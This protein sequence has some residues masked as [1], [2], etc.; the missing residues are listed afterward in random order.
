MRVVAMGREGHTSLLVTFI[1]LKCIT[2]VLANDTCRI[3]CHMG[4]RDRGT[5]T[6]EVCAEKRCPDETVVC[7]K[8]DRRSAYC[9][10]SWPRR[11]QPIALVHVHESRRVKWG[12]LVRVQLSTVLTVT[13]VRQG[14]GGVVSDLQWRDHATG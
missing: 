7:A 9:I 6:G 12:A 4:G 11:K 14:P 3:G 5:L 10:L 13:R 8:T 1:F 2:E